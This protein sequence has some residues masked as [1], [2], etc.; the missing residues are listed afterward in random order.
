MIYAVL[1]ITRWHIKIYMFFQKIFNLNHSTPGRCP[2]NLHGEWGME[3]GECGMWNG[4]WGM[5]TGGWG[6]EERAS[7]YGL[8]VSIEPHVFLAHTG[9]FHRLR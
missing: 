9:S 2:A 6:W 3:T 1:I 7:P 5:E 4:E 8:S